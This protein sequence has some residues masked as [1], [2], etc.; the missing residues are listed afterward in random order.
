MPGLVDPAKCCGMGCIV[1]HQKLDLNTDLEIFR[2]DYLLCNHTEAGLQDLVQ[3]G[4]LAL[5]DDCG[6]EVSLFPVVVGEE[7]H[8]TAHVLQFQDVHKVLLH[9]KP[10][11]NEVY[12][13]TFTLR[14]VAR[15]YV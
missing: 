11:I 10:E 12:K 8:V 4:G 9:G 6:L 1:A 13:M 7:I 3:L 2:A 5:K 15:S 14:C